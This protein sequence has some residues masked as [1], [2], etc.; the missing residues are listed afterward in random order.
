MPYHEEFYDRAMDGLTGQKR[1]LECLLW[2]GFLAVLKDDQVRL[3]RG[4]PQDDLQLLEACGL[5]IQS[6]P[7]AFDE[8]AAVIGATDN[9]DVLRKVFRSQTNNG[10]AGP[11]LVNETY[12]SFKNCKFGSKVPVNHLDPGVALLV[13][14]LPAASVC[15]VMS[16]D[17]H[18][19][20]PP[21]IWMR[22]TWDLRWSQHVLSNIA[23]T[24]GIAAN[25]QPWSF[26]DKGNDWCNYYLE[27]NTTPT[28]DWFELFSQIQ[29]FARNLLNADTALAFRH[30]KQGIGTLNDFDQRFPQQPFAPSTNSHML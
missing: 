19:Q 9:D 18:Y 30:E 24:L 2:R 13:K 29:Q 6:A 11:P 14:A 8:Y 21:R 22:T 28:T 23:Q 27:W 4:S 10:M 7:D 26:T 3:L 16:C 5:V 12:S 1:L 15:T 25:D 20:A 17:G